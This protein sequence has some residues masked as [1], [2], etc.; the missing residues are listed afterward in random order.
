[1]AAGGIEL[2]TLLA[3]NNMLIIE[4]PVLYASEIVIILVT[5]N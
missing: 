3:L 5:V 2:K 4:P 1:V